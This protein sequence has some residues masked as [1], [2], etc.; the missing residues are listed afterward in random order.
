M[1]NRLEESFELIS[2]LLIMIPTHIMPG[3]ILALSIYSKLNRF[4]DAINAYEY[5]TLIKEDFASAYFNMGNAY[6]NLEEF[7]KAGEYY[8]KTLNYEEPN[9]GYLLLSGVE[10]RKIRAV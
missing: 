4:Q 8:L 7:R 10:L 9:P 1:T 3:I 5:A 2:N 6:M